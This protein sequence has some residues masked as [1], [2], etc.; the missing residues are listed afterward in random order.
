MFPDLNLVLTISG[1]VLGTILTVISNTGI[2]NNETWDKTAITPGTKF[3][4]KLNNK[5]QKC[6]KDPKKFGVDN[7]I[8][9]GSDIP[10]EGEH[11]LFDHIKHN[12]ETH[13][14]AHTVVYGLDAD[15]I[16]LAINHL[17]ISKNIYLFRI[18]TH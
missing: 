13:E 2:Y 5:V 6:F 15:L 11:K 17:P 12:K 14:H 3:M 4:K 10:G 7:I 8:I 9:S 16:M 18:N 1:A